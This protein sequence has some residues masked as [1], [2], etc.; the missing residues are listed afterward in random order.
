MNQ[1]L[2]YQLS[3]LNCCMIYSDLISL[4]LIIALRTAFPYIILLPYIIFA[5][6]T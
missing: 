6:F 3:L 4:L 1:L 2:I 5:T